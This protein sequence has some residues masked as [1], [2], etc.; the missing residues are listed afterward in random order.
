MAKRTKKWLWVTPAGHAM[1]PYL[2][3][4]DTRFGNDYKVDLVF[5]GEN[6][7]QVKEYID[8][9]KEKA[10]E[11]LGTEEV[12]N[13][14]YTAPYIEEEGGNIRLKT[15]Q[16][17]MLITKTG[18][19]VEM[20]VGTFDAKVQPIDPVNIQNGDLIKAEVVL[21]PYVVGGR[22]GITARLKNVQLL[23]KS[24]NDTFFNT[25]FKVEEQYVSEDN[26][27][28][29]FKELLDDL[30]DDLSNYKIEF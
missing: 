20:K 10:E 12:S 15:K 18:E 27:E 13:K 5:T 2:A 21:I 26:P 9:L 28:D 22:W 16:K 23:S 7:K 11:T 30:E 6:A 1:Y 29:A 19:T 25:H 8:S 24:N 3:T 4:P 14:I 17:A